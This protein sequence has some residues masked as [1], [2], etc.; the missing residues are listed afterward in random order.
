MPHTCNVG[1]GSCLCL[2]SKQNAAGIRSELFFF[3]LSPACAVSSSWLRHRQS[4]LPPYHKQANRCLLG[5]WLRTCHWDDHNTWSIEIIC[6]V[7]IKDLPTAF[8]SL[9]DSHSSVN[10]DATYTTDGVLTVLDANK[11]GLHVGCTAWIQ[12][13]SSRK[14]FISIVRFSRTEA[15]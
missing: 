5:D 13:C 12:S 10:T 11:A 9:L 4:L 8:E 3:L 7:P 2:R 6:I 14:A 1:E 15:H